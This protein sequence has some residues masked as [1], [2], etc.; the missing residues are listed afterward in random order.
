MCAKEKRIAI[1]APVLCRSAKDL[2]Q[3]GADEQIAV[4][5]FRRLVGFRTAYIFDLAQTEGQEL[6][7]FSRVRGDPEES[8]A[9]LKA[10]ACSRGIG[11][12]YDQ[13]IVPAYG[14][15]HGGKILLLPGLSAAIP[16]D[17]SDQDVIERAKHARN[18]ERFRCLWAGDA[19]DYENDHSRADIALCRMLMFWCSETLNE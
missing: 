13:N 1:L 15:S 11:L 3:S 4:P 16:L 12:E 9:A 2:D 19:S 8:T 6:P 7:E 17:S 5:A 10:F 14:A 18:G